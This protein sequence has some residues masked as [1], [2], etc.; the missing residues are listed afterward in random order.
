MLVQTKKMHFNA[1]AVN[2]TFVQRWE[3]IRSEALLGGG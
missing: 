3:N 1:N 2:Q